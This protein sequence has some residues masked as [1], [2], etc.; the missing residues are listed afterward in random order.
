M[1][2]PK[3]YLNAPIA[4]ASGQD[5][6]RRAQSGAQTLLKELAGET[7]F[8]RQT[9]LVISRGLGL[10]RIALKQIAVELDLSVRTLQRRLNQQGQTFRE[11]LDEVRAA[12]AHDYLSDP[13]LPLSQI[14]FLLGYTEQSTFQSAFRRWTGVAPGRY[15]RERVGESR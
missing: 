14:A 10:G 12:R 2:F 13:I 6:Q 3:E 15:R 9:Q 11:V 5:S 8:I 7:E 4:S 1:V